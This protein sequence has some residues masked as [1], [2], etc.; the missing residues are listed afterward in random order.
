MIDVS[1]T[2]TIFLTISLIFAYISV[3]SSAFN[4]SERPN[5]FQRC[6]KSLRMATN[7]AEPG[8]KYK[9]QTWN[10]L[11]LAVLR[12]GLTEPAWTSPLNYEK[13]DGIFKCAYCGKELFNSTMKYDSGS[14][15]PS[16]WRT[17]DEGSVR[18]RRELDGRLECLCGRCNSH[19]GHAFL[20]G[21]RKGQVPEDLATTIPPSD[22]SST[23]D[24]RQLP[25]FCMNGAALQLAKDSD[26]PK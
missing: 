4:R 1:R 10:P 21:P 22:P 7:D 2:T 18:Y 5:F 8:E 16:F 15:W 13:K 17:I 12:L 25:R 24:P 23:R 11:R 26:Q 19:L 20:D 3:A 6:P 14:G 9:V